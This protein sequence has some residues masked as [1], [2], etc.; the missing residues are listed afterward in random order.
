MPRRR[1]AGVVLNLSHLQRRADRTGLLGPESKI[2]VF[3]ARWLI[4]TAILV[5]L[6]AATPCF[7]N[8]VPVHGPPHAA[9]PA[10]AVRPGLLLGAPVLPVR[11]RVAG[12]L[13]VAQIA[14]DFASVFNRFQSIWLRFQSILHRFQSISIG[15]TSVPIDFASVFNRFQ[16]ILHRFQSI[17]HRFQSILLRFQSILH[18]FSV[19]SNRFY[20]GSNRFC[21]DFNRFCIG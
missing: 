5:V 6:R 19:D 3:C 17:L 18:R 9:A 10:L 14:I 21:I 15:F 1:A 2:C 16:S 12:L 4:F 20:I 11:G 8:F 7:G 13:L